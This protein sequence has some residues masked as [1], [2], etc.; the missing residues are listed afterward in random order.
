MVLSEHHT[1]FSLLPIVLMID[2]TD[3][4]VPC[5][6][7]HYTV[8]EHTTDLYENREKNLLSVFAIYSIIC[9][10]NLISFMQS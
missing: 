7:G 1:L 9:F 8:V 6:K 10:F 4:Y 2:L 5:Q 3:I